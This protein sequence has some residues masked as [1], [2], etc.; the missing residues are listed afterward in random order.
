MVKSQSKHLKDSSAYYLPRM[1]MW[2]ALSSACCR[3]LAMYLMDLQC[4]HLRMVILAPV[5]R[6]RSW[7]TMTRKAPVS[8][9]KQLLQCVLKWTLSIKAYQKRKNKFLLAVNLRR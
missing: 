3:H 7:D 8:T 2:N 4:A 6:T 5:K 9:H 1:T